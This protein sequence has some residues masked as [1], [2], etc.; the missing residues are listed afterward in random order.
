[1]SGKCWIKEWMK[2]ATGEGGDAGQ[3]VPA[4]GTACRSGQPVGSE[5]WWQEQPCGVRDSGMMRVRRTMPEAKKGRWET[6]GAD[7][8]QG[9][10]LTT[11][12]RTNVL[13]STLGAE[14]VNG[15]GRCSPQDWDAG[16]VYLWSTTWGLQ[17]WATCTAP[18]WN[19]CCTRWVI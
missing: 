9:A 4:K 12:H 14:A 13:L 17:I 15:S 16:G 8:A 2:V 7:S 18:R 6:V 19:V 5:G 3:G 11:S 10:G 1:M